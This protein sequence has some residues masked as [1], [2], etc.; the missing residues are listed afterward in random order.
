MGRRAS[1]GQLGCAPKLGCSNALP[2]F[3]LC[4]PL[5]TH[6]HLSV[7][8]GLL[9][10]TFG[11]IMQWGLEGGIAAGVVFSTVYFA[12]AY[13]RS[14]VAAI[15]VMDGARSS[16][17]RTVE[18]QARSGAAGLLA[19]GR[20]VGRCGCPGGIAQ[21]SHLLDRPKTGEVGPGQEHCNVWFWLPPCAVPH[22]AASDPACRP[23]LTC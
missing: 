19:S 11:A 15:D 7:E 2:G 12:L 8:Y 13:A 20:G 16:V 10:A 18:Q 9:L 1:T 3:K 5:P 21:E 6:P 22:A 4:I 17:V 14:Q 23:R